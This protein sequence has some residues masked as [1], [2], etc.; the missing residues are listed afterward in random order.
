MCSNQTGNVQFACRRQP[1]AAHSS[2]PRVR[3]LGWT[4]RN[5]SGSV[6]TASLIN[7][8]SSPSLPLRRND[9][10]ARPPPRT[11]QHAG[12][13]SRARRLTRDL[14]AARMLSL[15]RR[16]RW[17]TTYSKRHCAS[18]VSANLSLRGIGTDMI[19]VDIL[20]H[21]RP[22]YAYLI[23]VKER[24]IWHTR[25]RFHKNKRK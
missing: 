5:A 25:T 12:R 3:E 6:R 7:S 21:A 1:K 2:D 17:L 16:G 18:R 20:T 4:D 10:L 14:A 13:G 11:P 23:Q 8:A 24:V 15:A 19:E 9:R 22:I